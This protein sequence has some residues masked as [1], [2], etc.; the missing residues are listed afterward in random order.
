VKFEEPAA[1]TMNVTVFWDV[2]PCAL[3][4]A[5][6]VTYNDISVIPLSLYTALR[7]FWTLATSSVS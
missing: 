3:V 1:I 4:S 7:L 2:T 5:Y 6:P